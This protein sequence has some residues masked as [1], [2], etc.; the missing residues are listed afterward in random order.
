MTKPAPRAPHRGGSS[1][2]FMRAFSGR[3]S[4]VGIAPPHSRPPRRRCSPSPEDPAGLIASP[5]ASPRFECVRVDVDAHA[6]P[7]EPFV[8]GAPEPPS[9]PTRRRKRARRRICGRFGPF[10]RRWSRYLPA[11]FRVQIRVAE[12]AVGLELHSSDPE[13]PAGRVERVRRWDSALTV[14]GS[15]GERGRVR[16]S[17][18]GPMAH[19]ASATPP[20]L[21]RGPG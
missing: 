6:N 2:R 15:I 3:S 5:R 19:T 9:R 18:P 17:R 11:G 8:F 16:G 10:G 1:Q 12:A 14:H 20:L 7:A 21:F 13:T 4:A